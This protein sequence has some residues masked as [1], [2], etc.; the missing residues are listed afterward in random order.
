M[1]PELEHRD[2]KVL[3][4]NGLPLRG[5]STGG[6]LPATPARPQAHEWEPTNPEEPAEEARGTQAQLS[7]RGLTSESC[8]TQARRAGAHS[9]QGQK[10]K[11]EVRFQERV[12]LLLK[13]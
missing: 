11:A 4:E 3:V 6:R 1:F 13:I 12:R 7:V 5:C 2:W 9:Q 8:Y 10:G